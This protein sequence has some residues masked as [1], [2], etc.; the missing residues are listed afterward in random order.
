MAILALAVDPV[1]LR[2]VVIDEAV[3]RLDEIGPRGRFGEI[4]VGHA[5]LYVERRLDE[6]LPRLR[7]L[8]L[9]LV[10][11]PRASYTALA[12]LDLKTPRRP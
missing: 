2:V 5:P 3:A 6:G 12:C 11:M 8:Y 10:A 9:V 7:A 4:P 1:G